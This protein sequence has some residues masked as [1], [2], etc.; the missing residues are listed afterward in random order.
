MKDMEEAIAIWQ[1]MNG[2]IPFTEMTICNSETDKRGEF[3]V[4]F[5]G[6]PFHITEIIVPCVEY[7]EDRHRMWVTSVY[8]SVSIKGDVVRYG[9]TPIVSKEEHLHTNLTMEEI[10]KF[11]EWK[12]GTYLEEDASCED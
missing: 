4:D 9:L 12:S 6:K 7:N 8:E 1:D 3:F 5:L 2:E 10:S 11:K